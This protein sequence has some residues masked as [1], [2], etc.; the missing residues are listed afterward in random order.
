MKTG[1]RFCSGRSEGLLVNNNT[2]A[3]KGGRNKSIIPTHVERTHRHFNDLKYVAVLVRVQS[4]HA[5]TSV[6]LHVE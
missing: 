3:N 5:I 4:T 1:I 2:S 6:R